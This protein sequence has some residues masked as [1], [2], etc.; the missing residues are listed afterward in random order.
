MRS[1]CFFSSYFSEKAIPYYIRFYLEQLAPHF[2]EMVLLTNEKQLDDE[3][4]KYLH[5]R[6]IRLMYVKNEGWDF[7]MWYKASRQIDLKNYD[8]VG[9]VNDSC[10]LF[11]SP[12]KFFDW[13]NASDL[14]YAGMVDSNAVAY[15]IQSYFLIINKNAIPHLLDYFNKH[16]ILGDVKEVIRT[17]E[18]GLTQYMSEKRLKTGALHSTQ[19]YKGEFSP[20]FYMP[21]ELIKNGLPMIKKK[22]I[23]CSFRRDEHLTLM[24]M[25]YKMHP[26]VYIDL[27][28][29]KYK[30]DPSLIDFNKVQRS[31]DW[32]FKRMLWSYNLRSLLFGF[33]RK[34]KFLK[35]A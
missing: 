8:R 21:V 34:F 9:L 33:A 23:H 15:H 35:P 32:S 1:I 26:Q 25:K 13:L 30:D 17:Y 20:M 11:T 31:Y 24:R 4:L 18:I 16:G 27:I 10:V 29:E 19:L 14:D 7:G 22:I 12:Q 2:T 3:S 6:N 28:R 5:Y